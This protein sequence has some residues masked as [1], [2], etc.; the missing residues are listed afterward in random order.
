MNQ[1]HEFADESTEYGLQ[2]LSTLFESVASTTHKLMARPG[3]NLGNP[4]LIFSVP[5]AD[6]FRMSIIANDAA[7]GGVA[8][9]KLD[10]DHAFKLAQFMLKGLVGAA[11]WASIASAPQLT[12]EFDR[13][14]HRMG[15]QPYTAMQPVVVNVRT[16]GRRGSKLRAQK[17][18][19]D[20]PAIGYEVAFTQR[21]LLFVV[22]G[23]HRRMGIELVLSFLD[24]LRR[25]R[26]YPKA[27]A[28]LYPYGEDREVPDGELAVWEETYTVA[29]GMCTVAVEAHLGLELEEERQLFHD[30]N[31]LTKRVERSLALEFDSSNP[32]NQFIK[33]SLIESDRIRLAKGD[34]IDWD[35]SD[36]GAMTRKDL[37][38]VNAHLIL[39][40]SNINGATAADVD[41]RSG[42]ATRYWDAV[43]QCEGFGDKDA[44][45]R[46][47]LAQ[48]VVLKAVAKLTY[49]FA[50]GRPKQR[51]PEHLDR[52]LD[53]LTDFDFGHD[54]PIWRYYE[55]SEQERI[56]EK[57][58]GLE[59]YLP[60]EGTGNRD[61]GAFDSSRNVMRFGSKHNDIFPIIGDMIRYQLGLPSRHADSDNA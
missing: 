36:T 61:V 27:K 59:K 30:L 5:M 51:N 53:G 29:R 19:A 37:V 16:A 34:K 55:F 3:N 24:D 31:N 42:V 50:F 17:F 26:V 18:P 15:P 7:V 32:V 57:I 48:P 35:D 23:Q 46:T 11:K 6:F 39:N 49:D 58:V 33:T 1:L 38:A 21:D 45:L 43:L 54:N 40:K 52:L 44:R 14:L 2:S 28:S 56:A 20:G 4:T 22:D 9:R 13:V 47:V 10:P 8:Q 25:T 12:E 41:E 60:T